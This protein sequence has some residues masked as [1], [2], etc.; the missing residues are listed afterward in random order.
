MKRVIFFLGKGGVG[1]TTSSA[2]LSFYLSSQKKDTYWVSIDPAH[3]IS[4]IVKEDLREKRQIEKHLFAEEVDVEAYL[5]N[6][7]KET[8]KKMKE[9]YKYLQIVNLESMFDILKH[10]PGMEEYSMMYALKEKIESN[11]NNFE[12]IVVDTPPTGLMLKIISLPFSSKM[13]IEKLITWRKKIIDRRTAI[14]NINPKKIDSDIAITEEEDKVLKE[15]GYQSKHVTF[16]VELLRNKNQ[17]KMVVVLNED[18]M[19]LSESLKIKEGLEDLGLS[20]DFVVLNKE[21]LGK[22]K[23]SL[24][25]KFSLPIIRM[26]YTKNAMDKTTLSNLGQRLSVIVN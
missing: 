17:S 4:D 11:M 15:L 19:S 18:E 25:D 16:M 24:E 10:S 21:G 22:I 13:W 2:A 1:K 6:F 5:Q 23:Y 12:Y 14:A 9:T 26:P 7:L 20:L 3:N 8:T